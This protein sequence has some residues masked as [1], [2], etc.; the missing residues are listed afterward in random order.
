MQD[1]PRGRMNGGREIREM[2]SVECAESDVADQELGILLE[3]VFPCET[4]IGTGHDVAG[5]EQTP[6]KTRQL[7]AA[8]IDK[9]H[10]TQHQFR[11]ERPVTS[12][13]CGKKAIQINGPFHSIVAKASLRALTE[14][15]LPTRIR[16]S[17]DFHVM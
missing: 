4:E 5:I 10:A 2:E 7:P 8:R 13:I 6:T 9:E 12:Q 3:Q 14:R 11:R 1:A 15:T 17:E 16:L